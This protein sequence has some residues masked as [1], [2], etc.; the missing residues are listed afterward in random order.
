MK[1]GALSCFED[2]LRMST[3]NL[4]ANIARDSGEGG[5]IYL[6]LADAEIADSVLANNQA[7]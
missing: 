4:T 5:A 6:F 3:C 7:L 1:G 2:K